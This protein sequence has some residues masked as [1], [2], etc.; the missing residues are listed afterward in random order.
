MSPVIVTEAAGPSSR[1]SVVRIRPRSI[2]KLPTM[3]SKAKPSLNTSRKSSVIR[4]GSACSDSTPSSL[5][6]P[7]S[8]FVNCP[9][10][11]CIL[12]LPDSDG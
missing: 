10:P 12:K 4:R 11:V 3:S 1:R 6:M 9:A 2:W 7:G 8:I 5:P